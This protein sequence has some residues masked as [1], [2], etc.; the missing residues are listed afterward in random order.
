MAFTVNIDVAT[1]NTKDNDGS[2]SESRSSVSTESYCYHGHDKMDDDHNSCCSATGVYHSHGDNKIEDD[3]AVSTTPEDKE[4]VDLMRVLPTSWPNDTRKKRATVVSETSNTEVLER[5]KDELRFQFGRLNEVRK[6]PDLKNEQFKV[7]ERIK[8]LLV[9][10]SHVFLQS[11]GIDETSIFSILQINADAQDESGQSQSEKVYETISRVL[12]EIILDRK[13]S[14]IEDNTT[15]NPNNPDG[16]NEGVT[17]TNVNDTM[18]LRNEPM[19]KKNRELKLKNQPQ[20]IRLNRRYE[21]KEC[22][23]IFN[24]FRALGGHMASHNRKNMSDIVKTSYE[25]RVCNVVFDDFRAL[26]GHIASHNRK[27][28]AHETASDP[29][30]VAESVGS[31]QKFYACNICSKRFSTG[32][33]LGG[34]KTYHRKIADALGIQASSG[35]SPGLE[36]DLNAAPDERLW[37]V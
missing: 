28:R 13:D 1:N 18:S 7:V 16:T 27:K 34:H 33:A 12:Q 11:N 14:G 24:D 2:K 31:R 17:R 22:K 29:G 25:C 15:H 10:Q 37:G 36:L 20:F 3:Y 26:G 23:Q 19:Q 9:Q 35:T 5:V 30:L 6:A 21:C 4:P 8:E 32:Q